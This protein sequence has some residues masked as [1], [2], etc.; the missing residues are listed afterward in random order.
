M[1]EY[2]QMSP[3][4]SES[5][6]RWRAITNVK[7]KIKVNA[8]ISAENNTL[9]VSPESISVGKL[10]VPEMVWMGAVNSALDAVEDSANEALASRLQKGFVITGVYIGDHYFSVTIRAP[11]P[12]LLS[13]IL[14]GT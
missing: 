5:V 13:N 4:P 1:E 11:P 2:Q 14:K 10:N 12:D 9:K 6:C 8:N 3:R 7:P